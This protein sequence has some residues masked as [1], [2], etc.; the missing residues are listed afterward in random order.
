MQKGEERFLQA[1]TG[2]PNAANI[3]CPTLP[4]CAPQ[5]LVSVIALKISDRNS[6]MQ[7]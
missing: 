1:F 5:R 6:R 7:Y 2:F 3:L 4:T